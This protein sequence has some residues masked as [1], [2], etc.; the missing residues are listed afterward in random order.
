MNAKQPVPENHP[1]RKAWSDYK[2]G[3][4]FANTRNW[5]LHEKHVDASLWAAF[6]AG[7]LAAG[8]MT[9]TPDEK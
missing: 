2:G 6:T 4:D 1:I 8:G 5:A 3:E 7:Y 9:F